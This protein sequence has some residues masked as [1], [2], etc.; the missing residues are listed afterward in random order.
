MESSLE[1][2]QEQA[3]TKTIEEFNDVF[4]LSSDELK[5]TELTQHII[6]TE[7]HAPIKQLSR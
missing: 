1:K 4:A 3:L 7:G 5:C 2:E 6:D